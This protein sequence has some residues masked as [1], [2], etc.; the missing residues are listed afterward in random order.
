MSG[1]WHWDKIHCPCQ[2]TALREE[3]SLAW[4]SDGFSRAMDEFACPMAMQYRVVNYYA[5]STVTSLEL[6]GETMDER[7]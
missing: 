5:F 2:Q 1:L 4:V 7:V 3:L 6:T